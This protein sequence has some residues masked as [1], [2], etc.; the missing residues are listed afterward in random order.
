MDGRM[1]AYMRWVGEVH[2]QQFADVKVGHM[3]VCWSTHLLG[4]LFIYFHQIMS[5]I[6]V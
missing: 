4:D 6:Y 3:P 2:Y 5:N 1:D